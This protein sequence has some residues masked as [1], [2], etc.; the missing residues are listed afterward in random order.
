[1]LYRP[2][3]WTS[4][5][6]EDWLFLG[7]QEHYRGATRFLISSA[8]AKTAFSLAFCIKHRIAKEGLK[9][10]QIVG[11]TSKRNV[12]FTKGLG[13]YDS[14]VDYDTFT[15]SGAVDVS[16][17]EKWVYADVAGNDELNN[18]IWQHFV[19]GGAKEKLVA[20]VQ[21]G[22]TTLAP[23]ATSKAE[24][25]DLMTVAD[26][27]S[28]SSKDGKLRLEAFFTVVWLAHRRQ[29]L[30]VAQI[31]EI[32][33]AAWA[34]LMDQGKDWVKLE[35]VYGAEKVR[36]EY[37]RVRREGLG[38]DVGQIWSLWDEEDCEL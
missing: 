31:A 36:S 35:R 6:C 5:W 32:Q 17:K 8:S 27:A 14:V 26:A 15:Q 18:R 2:L 34:A 11:L 33:A 21:L 25:V 22:M 12:N 28:P 23:D 9:G 16:R 10:I 1:M 4:F 29:S 20:A 3:F 30:T 38:P 37:E 24:S 13:L 19:S 7:F